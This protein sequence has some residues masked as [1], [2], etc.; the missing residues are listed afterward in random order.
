MKLLHIQKNKDNRR[1]IFISFSLCIT[2]L[3]VLINQ[4]CIASSNND[5]IQEAPIYKSPDPNAEKR[6]LEAGDT[7]G[8]NRGVRVRGVRVRGVRVRGGSDSTLSHGLSDGLT[9]DLEGILGLNPS[10]NKK[11]EAIENIFPSRLAP[12]AS[13]QTG[14]TSINMP[15]LYWY[16]SGAFNGQMEFKLNEPSISKPVLS[17]QL[18]GVPAEDIY[19]LKLSEHNIKLKPNIEYEWFVSIITDPEER[20][21]DIYASATIKYVEASSNLKKLLS[22]TPQEKHYRV[23]AENA[24]WYDSIDSISNMIKNSNTKKLYRAHRASLLKQVNLIKASKF[25]LSK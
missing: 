6:R 12:I 2:F 9:D 16:I 11:N 19:A 13:E 25:D 1:F 20:S 4:K 18:K 24:Y 7:D 15:T 3:L 23:Y 10:D 8:V 5:H 17:V 14:F 22:Q 21:G